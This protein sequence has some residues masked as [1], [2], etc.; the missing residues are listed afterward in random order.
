MPGHLGIHEE[1]H[2]VILRKR[3]MLWSLRGPDGRLRRNRLRRDVPSLL[4]LSR[5]LDE[6]KPTWH[7]RK[8]QE[9]PKLQ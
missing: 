7:S 4:K 6:W 3:W 9:K 8:C 1:L 5:R 2:R